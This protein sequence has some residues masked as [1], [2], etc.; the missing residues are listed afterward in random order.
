MG[1]VTAIVVKEAVDV[2]LVATMHITRLPQPQPHAPA[3]ALGATMAK[4][5]VTGVLHTSAR[6]FLHTL[7][8]SSLKL[9]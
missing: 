5:C 1:N 6:C 7:S 4:H 2:I 3:P 8:Q 9:D